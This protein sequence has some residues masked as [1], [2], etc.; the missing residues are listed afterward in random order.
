M[1]SFFALLQKNVLDLRDVWETRAELRI[2][3]VTW[4]EVTYHRRRRQTGL[5]RHTPVEFET[6]HKATP[7]AA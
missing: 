7:T 2:A 1:E 4:I 6:L 5:G 3:I